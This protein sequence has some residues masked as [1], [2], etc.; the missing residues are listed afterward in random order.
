MTHSN[1]RSFQYPKLI[2]DEACIRL[3]KIRYGQD[4]EAGTSCEIQA[5]PLAQC[6]PCMALSYTW[7]NPFPTDEVLDLC[8]R[9]YFANEEL[10]EQ[11]VDWRG[12]IMD[13]GCNDSLV[14]V[15]LNLNSALLQLSQFNEIGYFWI[16]RLCIDQN[17]NSEKSVQVGMMWKI[18]AQAN[19]VT[20]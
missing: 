13:I 12:E 16:D 5:F 15:S 9:P 14:F 7:G 20:V 10:Q 18:Y 3:L 1:H 2:D 8:G 11:D 6:P 17:N 4:S 19:L